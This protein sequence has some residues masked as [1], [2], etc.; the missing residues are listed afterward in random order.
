MSLYSYTLYLCA[1]G[2]ENMFLCEVGP[3]WTMFRMAAMGSS[4]PIV[5]LLV[6]YLEF[7]HRLTHRYTHMCVCARVYFHGSAKI[8]NAWFFFSPCLTYMMSSGCPNFLA[9]K[10][11]A[12]LFI[13]TGWGFTVCTTFSCLVC[14]YVIC[15]CTCVWV[16]VHTCHWSHVDLGG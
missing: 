15:M 5:C 12:I 11:D 4:S 6:S 8:E 10:F 2:L 1:L 13:Y 3:E 7:K 16:W 14:M 9:R